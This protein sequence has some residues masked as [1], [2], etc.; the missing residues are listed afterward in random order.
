MPWLITAFEWLIAAYMLS[1]MPRARNETE[2]QA[3]S[4]NVDSEFPAAP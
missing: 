4:V 1:R 2:T 3:E